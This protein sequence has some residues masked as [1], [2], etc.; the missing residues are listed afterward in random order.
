MNSTD[1]NIDKVQFLFQNVL[2]FMIDVYKNKTPITLTY[3]DD[4]T[5][6]PP[7]SSV[8]DTTTLPEEGI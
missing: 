6:L 2:A 3:E 8:D 4:T 5:T 1:V 7:S